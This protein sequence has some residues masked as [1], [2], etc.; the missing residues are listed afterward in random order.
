MKHYTGWIKTTIGDEKVEFDL[1]NEALEIKTDSA[2]GSDEYV[3]MY[4]FADSDSRM[5]SIEI[6]WTTTGKD[7][8]YYFGNCMGEAVPFS[9]SPPAGDEKIW[10][11]TMSK[12]AEDKEFTIH[13]N[14][15]EMASV[16]F[17]EV[18][19]RDSW[20][21]YWVDYDKQQKIQFTKYS[22]AADYYRAYK[23]GN[24]LPVSSSL[25]SFTFQALIIIS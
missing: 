25:L 14:D 11:I 22:V 1:E 13:C 15:E 9:K 7:P 18:C 8:T 17:S 5:G 23:P 3:Q 6:K 19:D 2:A 12:T 10:R 24:L 4:V 16:K 20:D 21:T